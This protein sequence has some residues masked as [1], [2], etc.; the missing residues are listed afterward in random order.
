MSEDYKKC[1]SKHPAKRKQRDC[2]TCQDVGSCKGVLLTINK[3]NI[4]KGGYSDGG[5]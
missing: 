1:A 3:R 2:L 5:F 4:K